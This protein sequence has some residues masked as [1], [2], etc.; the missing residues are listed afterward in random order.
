MT[1]PAQEPKKENA[2]M[3]GIGEHCVGKNAMTSIGLGSCVALI[4]YDDSRKIGAMAHVMLPDSG[5][6]DDRP[7]KYA[8]TAMKLLLP[9]LSPDPLH[10]RKITAKLAGGASMFEYFGKNLNIGERNVEAL[11]KYLAEKKIRIV[12]EDVGGKVGRTVT[13]LPEEGGKVLIK[14]ADGSCHEI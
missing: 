12:A 11:K 3:I 5:G 9:A 10:N 7:G 6:K 2:V 1:D 8:D 4:L 13:F 14:R